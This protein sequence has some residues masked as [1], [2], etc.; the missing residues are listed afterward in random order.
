[1][2]NLRKLLTLFLVVFG[3]GI[4]MA[5]KVEIVY[6]AEPTVDE[7]L[8]SANF[9]Q[10]TIDDL[11]EYTKNKLVEQIKSTTTFNHKEVTLVEKNDSE[12][13]TREAIR[14]AAMRLILTSSVEKVDGQKIKEIKVR[15]YYEWKEM[16]LWRLEDPIITRWSNSTY[17]FKAGTFYT[18]DRYLRN[19][20]DGLH[21]ST[22]NYYAKNQDTICWF[23]DLKAGYFLGIGGTIDK[24]YGFGEFILTVNEKSQIFAI[25]EVEST[26]IHSI[27]Y[28]AHEFTIGSETGY[29]ITDEYAVSRMTTSLALN[30]QTPIILQP[31]DYGFE[32]TYFYEEKTINHEYANDY[33]SELFNTKRLRCGYIE[34]QYIVLSPRKQDAGTAYLHF[35]FYKTVKQI[36]ADLA[37]WSDS[38]YLTATDCEAMIQYKDRNG[39]WVTLLDLL[40]DVTLTTDRNFP[41]TYVIN[42]PENVR[43]FR[44]YTTSALIGNR[45]KGRICIGKLLIFDE[46]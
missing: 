36:I 8:L 9:S 30:W 35:Q 13:A 23:A 37:L 44:F 4:V 10:E 15:L 17:S 43:E 45:N 28:Q 6:A 34:G 31:A 25:G 33:I 46:L 19:G 12:P 38:E 5:G 7:I 39:N 21:V 24:L 14:P 2:K 18:E 16:P 22:T 32:N 3:L 29:Q 26:Y 40:N 20:E 11:S 41:S 1:M 27:G 42:F